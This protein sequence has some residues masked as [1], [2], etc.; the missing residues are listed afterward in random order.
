MNLCYLCSYWTDIFMRYEFTGS[1]VVNSRFLDGGN[2]TKRVKFEL[3]N[4]LG[5]TKDKLRSDRSCSETQI[6]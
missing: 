5:W 1:W 2:D 4:R 3:Q 6:I